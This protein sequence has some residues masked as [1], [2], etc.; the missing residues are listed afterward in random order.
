MEKEEGG[1]GEGVEDEDAAT[2]TRVAEGGGRNVELAESADIF[3][4]LIFDIFEMLVFDALIFDR[5]AECLS[6]RIC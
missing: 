5:W 2:A 3:D 6:S 1:G 4:T